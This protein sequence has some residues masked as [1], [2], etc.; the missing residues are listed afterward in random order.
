MVDIPKSSISEGKE[1]NGYLSKNFIQITD[2]EFKLFRSFIYEN[3]G[4]NLTDAKRA[5]L[6][7]RL[8]K[9]LKR[10][11]LSSFKEYYE[12]V[13]NDKTLTQL[14]ELVD[15]VSTNHTFFFRERAHFD[16][17]VEKALP[18][19]VPQLEKRGK[20]DL[21]IWC[22]A[23]STGEEPYVMG[24]LVMEYLGANYR[25]WSAGVLA[26]DISNDALSAAIN[27]VYSYERISQVPQ[28]LQA[29]Y[30]EKLGPDKF[31]VKEKLRKEVLFRRFNLMNEVFP[32]KKPFHIIFC[33]NVMIYFDQKTRERL[34]NRLFD[35]TAS[36]GYLFIGNAETL[37]RGESPYRYIAPSIYQRV[38]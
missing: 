20:K 21:R 25:H 7:N 12:L 5:L 11:N 1:G 33:R 3:F 18:E 8:Q 6:M 34:V 28:K 13:R 38:T 2:Q 9:I 17:M 4:I 14:S 30:F 23:S 15:A 10:K 24:M 29:V 27:G 36:G 35:F 32:F 37:G 26:T 22:A 19:I 16:F 31:R